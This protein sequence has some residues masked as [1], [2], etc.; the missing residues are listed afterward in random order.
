MKNALRRPLWIVFVVLAL[1]LAMPGQQSGGSQQAPPSL[2]QP[3]SQT[4]QQPAQGQKGQAPNGQAAAPAYQPTPDEVTT[5]KAIQTELDPDRT[6]QLTQD[7]A[8]KY[9]KSFYLGNVYLFAANAYQQ[10]ND[11]AKSIEYGEKSLQLEPNSVPT[12][13]LLTTLL[14]QPQDMQGTDQDKANKLKET[15]TDANKVLDLLKTLPKPPSAT[16]DQFQK[17][18]ENI[19]SEVHSS[20]GMDHEQRALMNLSGPDPAEL[21][22][23]ETEYKLAVAGPQA[24]AQDY[25]RLGEV[26]EM[27]NKVGEAIDAFTKSGQLGQG[28]MMQTLAD[29]KIQQLKAKKPQ[30]TPPANH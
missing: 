28:T 3:N 10:K 6:I 17:I 1:P 11:V 25:Y 27:E 12:L 16:D 24:N 19:T 26:Y 15:E 22:K 4:G 30:P 8:K 7:F 21:G 23:A 13:V 29:Q 5:A 20:L 18:K 14:P 2:Q 9:P